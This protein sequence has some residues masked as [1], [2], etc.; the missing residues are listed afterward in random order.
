MEG[1]VLFWVNFFFS[2]RLHTATLFLQRLAHSRLRALLS[3]LL[4][5]VS[6]SQVLSCTV[7]CGPLL[8]ARCLA[9]GSSCRRARQ[10][11]AKG[12][13]STVCTVTRTAGR[14]VSLNC[15]VRIGWVCCVSSSSYSAVRGSLC[16][17]HVR[18]WIS[19]IFLADRCVCVLL[20]CLRTCWG[21]W[22]P[23]LWASWG[24]LTGSCL[25]ATSES[26]EV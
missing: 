8:Q 25:F 3:P 19:C 20:I 9:E 2:P 1:G 21:V 10:R 4:G 22:V 26:G 18:F 6:V 13:Y 7:A 15:I 16:D 24:G 12:L 23:V 11:T 17:S 5:F 14:G